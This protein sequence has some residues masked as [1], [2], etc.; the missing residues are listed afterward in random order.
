MEE[1]ICL[2]LLL[3]KGIK[4]LLN[5]VGRDLMDIQVVDPAAHVFPGFAAIEASENPA[6]L[7]K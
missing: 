4:I 6:V 1:V 5:Q 2:S 3:A 7:N